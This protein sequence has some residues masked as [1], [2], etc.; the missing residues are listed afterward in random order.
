MEGE[1]EN[2]PGWWDSF[3]SGALTVAPRAHDVAES[4]LGIGKV[5]E[6]DQAEA[7]RLALQL[8]RQIDFLNQNPTITG[9]MDSTQLK[10]MMK[11]PSYPQ[12]VKDKIAQVIP[13]L[14]SP[15]GQKITA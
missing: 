5:L 12:G 11:D 9:E 1:K 10:T 14:A 13:S 3:V 15:T 8:Q 2:T 4:V 7:K 6:T